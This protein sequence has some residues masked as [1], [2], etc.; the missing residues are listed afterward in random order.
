MHAEFLDFARAHTLIVDHIVVDG[1][2]HRV[3]TERKP[4]SRN[5]AYQFDGCTGWV[6][7]WDLHTEAI[8]FRAAAAPPPRPEPFNQARIRAQEIL[9]R[10]AGAAALARSMIR[11]AHIDHHEYL[12]RK[13]FPHRRG[14]VDHSGALLVPMT[15]SR[16]EPINVQ[17]ILPDGEK[18]FLKDAR[19]KGAIHLIGGR[20][21]GVW[22]VEGYA[23]GLSVY[24][25]LRSMYSHDSVLVCFSAGNLAHVAPLASAWIPLRGIVADNDASGTG[26]R[27]ARETGLRWVMPD[28]V[29]WD[30]ND[31]HRERGIDAVVRLL[32]EGK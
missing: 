7:A 2:V 11:S 13:G 16:G 3:P 30:A 5:G 14:L 32:M 6:Q 4:R 15:T 22:A 20:D 23:T 18:V 29:G 19:A 24:E 21:A 26:E 12:T 27:V 1:R 10:Q 31:L 25:A 8:A 9:T 17:R 28:V